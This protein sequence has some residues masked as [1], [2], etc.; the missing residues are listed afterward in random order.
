MTKHAAIYVRVSTRDQD[1]EA[2]EQALRKWL[3][4][5]EDHGG[6][7]KWYRDSFTGR[8]MKRPGMDELLADLRAGKL[9]RVVVWKLDRLGRTTRGLCMLFDE[10]R[11]HNVDLQSITEG[12][13]LDS[14][15]GRLQAQILASVAEY[16]TEIRAERQQVGIMAARKKTQNV[17]QLAGEGWS[18]DAICKHLGLKMSQVE[19]ALQGNGSVYWGGRGPKRKGDA[20]RV[21]ELRKKGLMAKEIASAMGLSLA[22]VFRRLKEAGVTSGKP[23]RHAAP[24]DPDALIW[25]GTGNETPDPT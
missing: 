11:K 23:G 4:I 18:V 19:R 16:E 12:F 1:P 8:V 6:A 17:R 3:A 22:T 10:L 7:T 14:P 13:S 5:Y 20:N 25:D 2:Q 24:D 9:S 21:V 15:A